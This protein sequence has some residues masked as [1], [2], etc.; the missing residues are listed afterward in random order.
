VP[1]RDLELVTDG[2]APAA[3]RL[4]GGGAP[5]VPSPL[6]RVRSATAPA[7]LPRLLVGWSLQR[8][9]APWALAAGPLAALERLPRL[10]LDGFVIAPA[11]WRIPA[12]LRQGQGDARADARAVARW[13]RAAGLPRWVQVG[14]GDQ[15]LPVD[16]AARGAAAD[17]RGCERAW[18]IWPPLGQ[19]LDQDG[20]RV[21]AVVALVAEPDAEEAA[22]LAGAARA[23]AAAG[24]VPPP[25]AAPPA[26]DWLTYKLYGPEPLQD[27]L[28]AGV[29]E[30]VAR[31]ARRT[32]EIR[33]WFF[34]RYA[35]GP[36][37]RPHLRLRVEAPGAPARAAFAARLE[38]ALAPARARGDV[39]T[40]ET[41]DYYPERARFGGSPAGLAAAHAVFES[42][43]ELACALLRAE[44]RQA[45]PGPDRQ[46]RLVEALDALARGLGLDLPARHALARSRRHAEERWA[47]G[48][49]GGER[50]A[51]DRADLD[52]AFRARSR[53]LRAAL[54][55]ATRDA[56]S[57]AFA[58]HA[59]RVARAT[60]RL[61]PGARAALAPALLHLSCVR[62]L[63][64][65][66]EA[67]LAAYTFWDRTL[68][69]LLRA[70]LRG[71]P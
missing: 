62:H 24:R 32:R 9:H 40:V 71:R 8:Q 41:A 25:R 49:A 11:S 59:A 16:L 3:L 45:E 38:A 58:R 33:R 12:D 15:L 46:S 23:A 52:R 10:S 26:A 56:C 13:R 37:P 39:V 54:G 66:R 5:L 27:D 53:Q 19:T 21:E 69:G 51:H 36:G 28:I 4:R 2:A 70:P 35:D 55:G 6:W 68:E 44:Q 1:P 64:P 31:A 42:D 50:A 22:A 29:L 7:G 67:E 60:G 57:R 30:P 48:P 63:G 47:G 17:L 14:E 34:L 65:D 43:S 18:E 20:R 61:P